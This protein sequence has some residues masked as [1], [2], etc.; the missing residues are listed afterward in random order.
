MHNPWAGRAAWRW[1]ISVATCALPYLVG[2]QIEE[3]GS[4]VLHSPE[5]LRE[6]GI[7]VHTGAGASEIDLKGHRLRLENGRWLDFEQLMLAPGGARRVPRGVPPAGK[8]AT[9]DPWAPS[10][11]CCC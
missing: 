8:P 10:G 11:H 2:G 5:Q 6:R 4:L 7:V 1:W 9:I 3:A